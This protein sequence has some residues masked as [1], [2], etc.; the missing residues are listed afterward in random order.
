MNEFKLSRSTETIALPEEER[1]AYFGQLGPSL[2]AEIERRIAED[3]MIGEGKTAR[4]FSSL[5]SRKPIPVCFKIWRSDVLNM[6]DKNPI[7][8]RRMQYDTPEEEFNLQ[9]KLYMAGFHTMPRPIAFE[10]VGDHQV[11]AME[12]LP[13]YTLEQIQQAGATVAEP[14]WTKLAQLIVDLNRKYGVAHR[15]LGTQNIFLKTD[16]KLVPG[17]ALKGEIFIIDLG[18]SKRTGGEPT[19]EDYTLT[20]GRNVIRYPSDWSNVERLQPH[21]AKPGIFAHS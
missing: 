14:G 3:P 6:K 4:V 16:E 7:D 21:P 20:I 5:E 11:M 2:R 12:E 8:Y 15:D 9:D 1:D 13:G 10:T 18:L 19:P 17:A